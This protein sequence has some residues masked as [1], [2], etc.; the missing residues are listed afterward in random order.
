MSLPHR[1]PASSTRLDRLPVGSFHKRLLVLVGAGLFFDAFDIY[2]ANSVLGALVQ[3]GWSSIGQ[4]ATFLSATA[5]GMLLGSVLAGVLGDRYGRK[6][7]YQFNLALFGLASLAC[8]AAP[9]I[10][11]LIGARFL[12]GVGLGAELVIGYGLLSEFVP[13]SHRGRWAALLSCMAQFGLFAA[14]LTSWVVIPTLG[15]RAMFVIAGI[16]GLV[17]FVMRKNIPESP[18]WL[19]EQGRT[20]EAEAIVRAIEAEAGASPAVAPTPA[21]PASPAVAGPVRPFERRFRRPLALGALTQIVQ[22]AAI[23]GFVAWVPTFLLQ[24]GIPINQSLGQSVLMSFGGPVGA[25]LAFLLSDRI[26][27]KAAIIGGSV[28][29]AIVGPLFALAGSQALATG[30][31]FVMFSLVYFLVS[32]IQAGYLPELFPTQVRMRL[33]SLAVTAGRLTSIATPFLVVFLVQAGGML[34]VVTVV[35]LLLLLQAAAMAVIGVET[36]RRSLEEIASDAAAAPDTAA[37][38]RPTS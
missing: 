32:V 26:G 12:T 8:A 37:M 4:N 34:A 25:L 5:F 18:R 7:T 13:P 35:A 21:G 22:S 6:F 2:L 23:Y 28:L 31:G 16:G 3:T 29:A 15:W 17:V 11:W 14:T 19:E 1:P 10:T 9:S 27:R 36:N 33:T 20:A 30:L 38:A 24:Q